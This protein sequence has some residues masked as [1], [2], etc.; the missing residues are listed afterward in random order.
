[1]GYGI[2]GLRNLME[3]QNS[4]SLRVPTTHRLALDCCARIFSLFLVPSG[5]AP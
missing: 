5:L 4:S 2:T 1:M 3:S